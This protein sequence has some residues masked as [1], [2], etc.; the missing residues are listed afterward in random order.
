[1]MIFSPASLPG[2]FFHP[3]ALVACR[4]TIANVPDTLLFERLFIAALGVMARIRTV[5]TDK[6]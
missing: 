5:Y 3:I 4:V 6:G 2:N 1:M